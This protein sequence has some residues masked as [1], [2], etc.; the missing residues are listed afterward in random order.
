MKPYDQ[1]RCFLQ[2]LWSRRC[3]C[4]PSTSP[5]GKVHAMG[6][7]SPRPPRLFLSTHAQQFNVSPAFNSLDLWLYTDSRITIC[8]AR[9]N[10]RSKESS[11]C[12]RW[13]G[14]ASEPAY[15]R[16]VRGVDLVWTPRGT[17]GYIMLDR[18]LRT[19]ALS[20][21]SPQE[22]SSQLS[23]DLSPCLGTVSFFKLHSTIPGRPRTQEYH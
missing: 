4:L 15:L 2:A 5:V 7:Q 10:R 18:S 1:L 12:C 20:I 23:Q 8:H 14:S 22:I 13:V 6:E 21:C 17:R 16:P 19:F 11:Q 9:M 3:H